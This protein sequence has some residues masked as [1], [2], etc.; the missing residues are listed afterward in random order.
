MRKKVA[1]FHQTRPTPRLHAQE[2][3]IYVLYPK[4]VS[5]CPADPEEGM[6]STSTNPERKRKK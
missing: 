5:T 4:N 3:Q 6:N 1:S 2:N